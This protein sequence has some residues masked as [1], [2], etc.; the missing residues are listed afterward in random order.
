V[1]VQ[2]KAVDIKLATQEL[3]RIREALDNLKLKADRWD[4]DSANAK[5]EG[6]Y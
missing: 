1:I 3:A 4:P 5:R 2:M 6:R